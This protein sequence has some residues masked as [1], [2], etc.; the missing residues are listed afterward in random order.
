[1]TIGTG[2]PDFIAFQ[3]MNKSY[4]KVIGVEVKMNGMLSK[5]EKEKCKLYL[6]NNTFT[7]L[8]IAEKVKEKNRVKIVYTDVKKI[9]ER[10]R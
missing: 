6:E 10:M 4:Y 5:I 2:F 8:L 1:M 7:E 3:K 9:L